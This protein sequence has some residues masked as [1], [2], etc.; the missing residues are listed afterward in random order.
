[1][2]AEDPNYTFMADFTFELLDSLFMFW[3]GVRCG[4][5][6]FTKAGRAKLAKIWCGRHHPLYRELELSDTIL[7]ER[8]PPELRTFVLESASI[9]T[10]GDTSTGEGADFRLEEINKQ[11]QHW[12]PNIPSTDDWKI[13]S[14]NYDKLVMLRE[15]VFN[16]MGVID[17]KERKS[18]ICPGH[19]R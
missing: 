6:D 10:S 14:C 8:M 4:N 19:C 11:I 16:Q 17:P 2:K 9:R 15:T 13:A 3:A 12:L 5:I 7:L 1:M 18:I